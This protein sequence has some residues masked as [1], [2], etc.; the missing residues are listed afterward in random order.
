MATGIIV[1]WK[2]KDETNEVKIQ[3][4]QNMALKSSDIYDLLREREYSYR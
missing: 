4:A 3:T 2:P 1:A